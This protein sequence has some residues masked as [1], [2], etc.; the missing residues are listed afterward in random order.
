MKFNLEKF[1]RDHS[2]RFDVN[3]TNSHFILEQCPVCHGKNK[4]YIDRRPTRT[5]Y[6]KFVC[7][8]CSARAGSET[9]GNIVRLVSLI[10]GISQNQATDLI[11]K[12]ELTE[13]ERNSLFAP[14]RFS[15]LH[16]DSEEL[17]DDLEPMMV[18]PFL[19]RITPEDTIAMT[20]LTE[21]RGLTLSDIQ[22]MDI[23]IT[24]SEDPKVIYQEALKHFDNS[25]EEARFWSMMTGRIC[26]PVR[27]AG[28]TFGFVARDYTGKSAAKVLNTKGSFRNALVW[29]L[30]RVK[31]S[32]IIVIGEGII[33]AAKCG[34]DRGVAT[35]GKF[36]TNAQMGEFFKLS[37]DKK[38]VVVSD[39]DEEEVAE[40][41]AAILRGYFSNVYVLHLPHTLA[42]N[43][44]DYLDAGDYT[45]EENDKR[46]QK[47]LEA[48][49][50]SM[51]ST[52]LSFAPRKRN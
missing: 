39:P 19:R 46:I 42:A 28:R 47:I 6:G 22:K 26:F 20:Y 16:D 34:V 9:K 38:I 37:P 10:A 49:T 52:G 18:P 3:G 5:K 45:F 36:I 12:G 29:N 23:H 43:Q 2:I 27:R 48:P 4:F 11:Y 7:H 32:E 13:E 25:K 1:L 41:N 50:E 24:S 44:K 15:V 8:K 21:K 17:E 51:S 30:D 33:T 40:K 31:D 35:L 14:P